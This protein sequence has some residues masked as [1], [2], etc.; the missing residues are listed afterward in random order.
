LRYGIQK[1]PASEGWPPCRRPGPGSR[2]HVLRFADFGDVRSP[3]RRER[4]L[5]CP[6]REPGSPSSAQRL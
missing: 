2:W 5:V 1:L 4:G 6:P 3:R